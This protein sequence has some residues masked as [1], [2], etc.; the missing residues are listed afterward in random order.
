MVTFL[1][2]KYCMVSHYFIRKNT[3][4]F[5]L[6]VRYCARFLSP[7]KPTIGIRA[8]YLE[9]PV[10]EKSKSMEGDSNFSTIAPSVFDG[11]NYQIWAVWME[12]YLE[13]LDLWEA[14]EEDYEI[15]VLPH[16]PT[17][18]QIKNHKDRK[19]R[20]AKAKAVPLCCSFTNHFH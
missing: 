18:A 11:E 13:A 8:F 2:F 7:K 1:S 20:K 9:G 10:R 17:M 3:K 19:T 14:V 4:V 6:Q 16:N 12:V 5:L 15:R